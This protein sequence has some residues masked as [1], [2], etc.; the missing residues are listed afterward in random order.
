[1]SIKLKKKQC[2]GPCGQMQFIF[3]N[4]D[5]KR[6]CRSCSQL[7]AGVAKKSGKSK[8]TVRQYPISKRSTKKAAE[9]RIYSK[10]RKKFLEDNPMCQIHLQDCLGLASEIHH[11]YSGK[12]RATHYLEIETWLG[13]CRNCHQWV[14]LHS[15]E[16]RN[17]GLLK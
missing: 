7:S 2:D 12:D 3:K 9:D 15:K 11:T 17:L 5:G 8:P 14:H 10:K 6:Y 13:T 1:M 16:A 4:K